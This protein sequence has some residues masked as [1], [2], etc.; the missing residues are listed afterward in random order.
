MNSTTGKR[1]VVGSLLAVVVIAELRRILDHK[2]GKGGANLAIPVGGLIAGAILASVA[3]PAPDVAATIALTALVATAI[4]DGPKV[5]TAI[6]G[7]PERLGMATAGKDYA[8]STPVSG[9]HLRGSTSVDLPTGPTGPS[10]PPTALVTKWGTIY[11]SPAFAAKLGPM[12]AAAAA[13]GHR[14]WGKAYRSPAE[15]YQLR[16]QRCPG[17]EYDPSCKGN[18]PT[19][20]PGKSRH[21]T[22]DAIDFE[23]LSAGAFEWLVEHASTYGIYNLPSER[24]HWSTDGH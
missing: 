13:D 24:W 8:N 4:T 7:A 3:G 17:R 1:I 14:L 23:N 18:P 2:D 5:A 11:A 15:Q 9:S 20:I 12:I 19:A 22:G 21:E 16:H 6:S 10:G